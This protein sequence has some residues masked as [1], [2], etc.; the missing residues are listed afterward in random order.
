MSN[1]LKR[2]VYHGPSETEAAL[3]AA[4]AHH[5]ATIGRTLDRDQRGVAPVVDLFTRRVIG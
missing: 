5:P 4:M 2:L 1:R 3:A